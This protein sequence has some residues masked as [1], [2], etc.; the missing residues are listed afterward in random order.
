MSTLFAIAE[1]LENSR[2]GI[3]I[4]EGRYA[5]PI[6]EGIHLIGL[7]VAVGLIMLIDL[8]LIGVFLEE[9]PVKK[10]HGQL[11]PYVL[12]GFAIV[13]LAGCLLFTSEATTVIVSPPWPFKA[14]FFMLGGA[15]ALYFEF[16]IARRPQALPDHGPLP[17]SVRRAGTASLVLWTLVII[18]GRL[19][20]YIT[21]WT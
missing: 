7:S 17:R 1:S 16:V 12:G 6:I 8:R 18:C 13:I 10:L 9:I 2:I 4:A 19:I 5:F 20:P 11:Q 15:N 21:K 3:A 14:F